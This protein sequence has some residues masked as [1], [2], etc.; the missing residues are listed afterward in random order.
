MGTTTMLNTA[1]LNMHLHAEHVQR[2]SVRER[3]SRR[4][5]KPDDLSAMTTT[6][7]FILIVA[8]DQQP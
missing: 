7:V 5:H 4:L 2:G 3:I 1:E 6:T 8:P